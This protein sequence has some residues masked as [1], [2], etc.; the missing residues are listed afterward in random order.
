MVPALASG[1]SLSRFAPSAAD[2]GLKQHDLIAFAQLQAGACAARHKLR[3]D[4]RG[5][6]FGCMAQGL[7]QA[8][9]RGAG[10]H[11]VRLAIKQKGDFGR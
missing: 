6:A 1:T 4:G 3:I 7:Y 10:R 9:Q 2:N 11:A 5:N 8:C